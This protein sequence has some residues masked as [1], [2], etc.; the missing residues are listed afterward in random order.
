MRKISHNLPVGYFASDA[1]QNANL[2]E[3]TKYTGFFHKYPVY[4]NFGIE[5]A[6]NPYQ[7]SLSYLTTVFSN[8]TGLETYD[9]ILMLVYITV[10]ISALLFLFIFKNRKLAILSAPILLFL[11][12]NKFRLGFMVGTWQ[13]LMAASLSIAILWVLKK[14]V[15]YKYLVIAVITAA[16]IL[17]HT[18]DA[19]PV[20]LVVLTYLIFERFKSLKFKHYI[21]MILVAF[22]LTT[23]YL[24]YVV[25][26]TKMHKSTAKMIEFRIEQPEFY[27]VNLKDFSYFKYVIVLGLITSFLFF[28]NYIYLFLIGVWMIFFDYVHYIAGMPHVMFQARNMLL[29]IFVCFFFGL[30]LFLLLRTIKIK[31]MILHYVVSLLF[32]ILLINSFYEVSAS[33]G[34]MQENNWRTY[35][36]LEKNTELDADVFYTYHEAQE[37]TNVFY[38][39]KRKAYRLGIQ[40]YVESSKDSVIKRFNYV[41]RIV[42]IMNKREGLFNLVDINMDLPPQDTCIFDYYVI[43]TQSNI[44]NTGSYLNFYNSILKQRL[45]ENEWIKEVFTL[46]TI[47]VLQNTE[48]SK[49]CFEQEG[50]KY[51]T[52]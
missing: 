27:S 28:K 37:Q 7:P 23:I 12:L 45:L 40:N 46:G 34:L 16:I 5:E 24:S 20:Y 17:S 2:A 51:E 33:P 48:P 19:I 50:H 31:S 14:D 13:Y 32:V 38:F 29:P 47:S 11:F 1:F 52:K 21:A 43:D 22:L 9:A 39:S 25:P 35:K 18:A 15:K 10:I 42:F 30:F 6:V 49:D 8:F 41:P 3:Y 44:P 4:F 36:W 26:H